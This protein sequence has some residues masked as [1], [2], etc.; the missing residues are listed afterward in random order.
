VSASLLIAAEAA[1]K[2]L[3]LAMVVGKAMNQEEIIY[4]LEE[5]LLTPVVVRHK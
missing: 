4:A 2:I 3:G 5:M 1:G